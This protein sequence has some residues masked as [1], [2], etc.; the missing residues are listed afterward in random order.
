MNRSQAGHLGGVKANQ[1]GNIDTHERAKKAA[2][3]RKKNDPD[4]FKKMGQIGGSHS[5]GGGRKRKEDEE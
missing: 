2:E 3:T 1:S 5:H 4:A